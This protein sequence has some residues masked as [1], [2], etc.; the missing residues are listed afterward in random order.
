MKAI[1]KHPLFWVLCLGLA[2]ML[3]EAV[4]AQVPESQLVGN[5]PIEFTA[6]RLW[7]GTS[8]AANYAETAIPNVVSYPGYYQAPDHMDMIAPW[9]WINNQGRR[10]KINLT[11]RSI[12]S[13]GGAAQPMVNNYNYNF[14]GPGGTNEAEQW[15]EGIFQTFKMDPASPADAMG[16]IQITTK[17]MVWSVPKY[18]DF[19][20]HKIKIKHVDDVPFEDFYM[21]FPA[22]VQYNN[23]QL[24][25]N[26]FKFK[27]D[28]Q[29]DWDPERKIFIFYDDVQWPTTESSPISFNIFEPP[30]DVTGDGGDPGNITESG[31][32]DRRLYEP[33]ARAWGILNLTYNGQPE[34]P[35][36]NIL[37]AAE[38]GTRTGNFAGRMSDDRVPARESGRLWAGQSW[39]QD[40]LAFSHDQERASW[41]DLWNDPSRPKDGSVDGNLFER[42]PMLYSYIGPYN[43]QP[44]DEIELIILYCFGEM[45]RNVSQ[46]G[47]LEAAQRYQ[48]EGIAALKQN[49]DSALELI[50][51]NYK[52]PADQYPPPL[53]GTQ[54]FVE[55][56]YPKLEA[57]PFADASTG[58]QGFNL[59]WQAVPDN[60][61]DPGT[62]ENDFAGYRIYR[63]EIHITGPWELLEDISASEAAAYKQGDKI[64][65]QAETDPGIPL[66]FA[67]T[68]YDTHG[69]ESGI[70]AYTFFATEAPKAPSDDMT[71]I[72]VV[73]NPFRQRS[74]LLDAAQNN[75]LAF[76]NIPAKCTIRIYTLAGDLIKI[77]EHDGFGETTWG[78]QSDGNYL[79][80]DFS[81]SPAAGLYIYHVTSHVAGQEGQS[82]VGKF[83]IIR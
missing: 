49:W 41:I 59:T 71:Q 26:A 32:L 70:T 20:I 64:V 4:N 43:F 11:E 44:G 74:G 83:M 55:D 46:R 75:R 72:R 52:L 57:E 78:S 39:E 79:Q 12:V 63:S 37:A 10:V 24:V 42:S 77:I 34:D 53:V 14:V 7:W 19:V 56:G 2:L 80:T 65:F 29:F 67:V 50:A 66:R 18:D 31:S 40:L 33:E 82:H 54:P 6:G 15:G 76:V 35:H 61:Q 17:T 73:P 62:G 9:I 51:N 3:S 23:G 48:A 21:C 25:N 28:M 45:D 68:S 1:R 38:S 13:F 81:E 58:S 5:N 69:L 47:G 16:A 22:Q 8:T 36:Y 30:G 60:Y 27:N